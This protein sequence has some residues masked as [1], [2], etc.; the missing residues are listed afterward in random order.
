[1]HTKSSNLN[2]SSI[3]TVHT[4]AILPGNNNKSKRICL[5]PFSDRHSHPHPHING[6]NRNYGQ[7]EKCIEVKDGDK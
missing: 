2:K 4:I 5:E 1:M 6:E 3:N 7:R